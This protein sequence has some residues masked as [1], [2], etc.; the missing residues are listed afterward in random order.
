MAKNFN[1]LREAFQAAKRAG[2]SG[3]EAVLAAVG[4]VLGTGGYKPP[5]EEPAEPPAD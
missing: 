1:A 2:L 4:E 5:K 3:E